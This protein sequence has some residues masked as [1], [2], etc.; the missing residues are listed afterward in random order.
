MPIK[1]LACNLILIS[2][3]ISIGQKQVSSSSST[4]ISRSKRIFRDVETLIFILNKDFTGIRVGRTNVGPDT[5]RHHT[6]LALLESET[7]KSVEISILMHSALICVKN[8]TGTKIISLRIIVFGRS[9]STK[10]G[11]RQSSS[12]LFIETRGPW[13]VTV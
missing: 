5:G 4:P 3:F 1:T 9:N 2:G 11:F 7:E 8:E 6:A 12:D 10:N 13:T